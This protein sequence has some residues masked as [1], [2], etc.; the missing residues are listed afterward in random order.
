MGLQPTPE[1]E[2]TDIL[3]AGPYHPS[4]GHMVY[5]EVVLGRITSVVENNITGTHLIIRSNPRNISVV[6]GLKNGNIKTLIR[7]YGIASVDVIG[8]DT[9][10]R[11][12]LV[13]NDQR[14]G[15]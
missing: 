3:I 10:D 7:R 2:N 12:M 9:L 4:F 6:R 11:N 13:V 5:S 1:T 14:I 15:V 8:D